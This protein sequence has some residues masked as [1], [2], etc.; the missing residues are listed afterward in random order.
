MTDRI[1]C[2]KL[3]DDCDAALDAALDKAHREGAEAAAVLCDTHQEADLLTLEE[4][5]GI[6]NIAE[7]IRQKLVA[8]QRDSS[9]ASVICDRG[10]HKGA[11]CIHFYPPGVTGL[12]SDSECYERMWKSRTRINELGWAVRVAEHAE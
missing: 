10:I 11:T 2:G 9:E 4:L 5:S 1:V 8:P 12:C 3:S 7:E 6:Y